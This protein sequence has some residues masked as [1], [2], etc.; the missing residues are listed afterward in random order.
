[1]IGLSM[2]TAQDPRYIL[3]VA[4]AFVIASATAVA[5]L[6]RYLPL[7][8]PVSQVAALAIA[9]AF[10]IWSA[11]R[12]QV[13]QVSGFREIVAFLQQ[14]APADAVMY[15]GRYAGLFGFYLRASDP[16][17]E[18]RMVRADKFLYH[19]APAATFRRVEKSYIPSSDD[20]VRLVRTKSGCR[21]VA[22]EVHD[23]G[24]TSVARGV[25]REALAR[26][27]FELVRSF[28]IS[29]GY[30]NRVDLYR[31]TVPVDPITSVDLE[32]P[33]FNDRKL[34][35]VVPIQRHDFWR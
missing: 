23:E 4:P 17:F 33:A 6:V 1:M 31:V 26:P 29:G 2:V 27:E 5:Y 30:I 3:V 32:F 28:P 15:E 8:H 11:T 7:R 14:L 20:V 9:L 18:R 10:G 21:W 25:L 35:G 12:I 16:A 34:S 22:I 24:D 13:P 19:R